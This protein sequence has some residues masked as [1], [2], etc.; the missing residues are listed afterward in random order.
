MRGWGESALPSQFTAIDWGV[1]AGYLALTTLLGAWLSGRQSTMRDFFLGGR[2]LPWLAVSG[3]IISTEIS[4]VTLIAVPAIVF[5]AGGNLT[6]LQLSLGSILARILVGVWFVPAF[7]QREIYSPYDYVHEHLGPPARTVTNGLFVL[8]SVLGQSVRVLLTALI[9][10]QIAGV[11]LWQSIWII[12]GITIVWTLLGGITTV[13]WTDVIQFFVFLAGLLVA[14]GVLVARVDGGWGAI[15]A[16]GAAAGKLKLLDLSIDP[17]RAFTLWTALLANTVVCLNAYGTDQMMVQRLLCCRGPRP[18][19]LAIV[20]SSVGLGIALLALFVGLGLF[21][22]Y[23]QH[24]LEGELAARVADK[25]ERIFPIFIVRELPSGLTGLLV[26]AVFAAAISSPLAALAQSTVHTTRSVL[27]WWR[28][29]EKPGA[30]PTAHSEEVSVRT[31]RGLVVL[32]GLV[33]GGVAQLM[34]F[35]YEHYGDILNLALAMASFTGG[36]LLAAFCLAFLRLGVDASG[37]AW[38]APLSVVTVFALAFHQPWATSAV[39]AAVVGLL[40]LRLAL[41]GPRRFALFAAACA[42]PAVLALV[43]LP[44][45]APLTAAWPWN[46]PL[47]FIVAFAWGYWL[48]SARRPT[49]ADAAP[50]P[51]V[52]LTRA[53]L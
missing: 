10:E 14:L 37:L 43:H 13:I 53:A 4:A 8:G 18:A 49:A 52:G 9:L 3:S 26:A 50:R 17:N 24:P 44:S 34:V 45:G 23:Q 32:W 19:C 38:S 16:A 15:W 33:L 11:A 48:A 29:G 42:L 22:F 25:A 20:C 35:A 2:K 30:A 5:A 7:Y 28:G 21:A 40:I 12:A 41:V 31:A 36:A 47:G 27:R 6:Y 39:L 1:L 51:A 46:V